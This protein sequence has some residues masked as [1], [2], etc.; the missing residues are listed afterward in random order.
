M[1]LAVSHIVQVEQFKYRQ[2]WENALHSRFDYMTG[3]HVID[4][5]SWGHLQV[6]M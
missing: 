5:E 2:S 4:D 3:D 6:D 1:L